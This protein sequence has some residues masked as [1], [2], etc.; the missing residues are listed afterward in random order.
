MGGVRMGM[1][2][3]CFWLPGQL[4]SELQGSGDVAN[5]MAMVRQQRVRF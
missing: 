4:Q 1:L 2:L 3:G 5:R